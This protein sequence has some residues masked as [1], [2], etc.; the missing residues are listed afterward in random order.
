[1][2]WNVARIKW[3]RY[4]TAPHLTQLV[5]PIQWM[6]YAAELSS[7]ISLKQFCLSISLQSA[8]LYTSRSYKIIKAYFPM[9][10]NWTAPSL[11][12][13]SIKFC[14]HQDIQVEVYSHSSLNLA[15]GVVWVVS[16]M[17]WPLTHWIPGCV[18]PIAILDVVENR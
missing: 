15:L 4:S 16:F 7:S 9:Q 11:T 5:L 6:W 10:G 17:P 3:S 13:S 18:A 1:V 12:N 8:W 2:N 14:L